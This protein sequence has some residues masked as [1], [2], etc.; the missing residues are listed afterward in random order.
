MRIGN[1]REQH[2]WYYAKP[3]QPWM[4]VYSQSEIQVQNFW[5]DQDSSVIKVSLKEM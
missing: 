2:Q 3:I 4:V 5:L 1:F